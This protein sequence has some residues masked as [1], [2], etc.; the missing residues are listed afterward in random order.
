MRIN[1][2]GTDF[3]VGFKY[4][5][6]MRTTMAY[7]KVKDSDFEWHEYAVASDKDQFNRKVGRKIALSRALDRMFDVKR[8]PRTHNPTFDSL[9]GLQLKRDFSPKLWVALMQR[10]MKLK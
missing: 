7:I 4:N 10:G 6:A 8:D 9:P 5:L 2:D 3:L 1:V